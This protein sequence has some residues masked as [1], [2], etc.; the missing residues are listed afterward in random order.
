MLT[1]TIFTLSPRLSL[2]GFRP[3]EGI[4]RVQNSYRPGKN[5]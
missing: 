1:S 4:A 3:A 5:A 2:D